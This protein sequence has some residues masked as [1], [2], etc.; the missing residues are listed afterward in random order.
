MAKHKTTPPDSE[1]R[2]R[3]LSEL[4]KSMLVEASAGTGKTT[5][6]VGRM[7]G[8]LRTGSCVADTLA[9]VTF[10][11]KS[12]AELRA[13]FQIG[14]EQ[15]ASS[16]ENNDERR[17]L[18]TALDGLDRSFIGTIH[19]FC[20]RLIRERPV[21]S[22]VDPGFVELDDDADAQ[23]RMQAWLEYVEEL[24]ATDDPILPEFE[25]LGLKVSAST[26]TSNDL[27]TELDELGLEPTDLGA[28]FL[29]LAEYPDV[30][31]W[32]A[33]QVALPDLTDCIDDLRVYVKHMLATEL[34]EKFGNDQ[35]MVKYRLIPRVLEQVQGDLIKPAELMPI[36]EQFREFT[37]KRIVQKNWLE[38]KGQALAE[39]DRWND[40]ALTHAEPLVQ[41]WR[42]HRYEPV[43]RAI[44]GAQ[45]VYDRL[46]REQ[47]TLNFQD[48]LLVSATLLR[49]QPLMRAYFRQRFSHLLIDEFQDTDPIQAEVMMLLTSD[50]DSETDWRLCRPSPGSL[51]VVGDPKQ[52]IYRFRRADIMTYEKVKTCIEASGGEVVSLTSN[53][54]SNEPI[55]NWINQCFEQVFPAATTKYSPANSPLQPSGVV[56][57]RAASNDEN[58]AGREGIVVL[59]H[60]NVG[61]QA[62]ARVAANEAEWIARSIRAAIDERQPVA[63]TKEELQRGLPEHVVPGDFMIV[64]RNRYKTTEYARA[65]QRYGLPNA[66]T[67][68]SI[69]NEVPEL[70]W[71]HLCLSSVDRADD[72]V[73]LVAVLRSELFGV[74][75]TT[76]YNFRRAGG[77]FNFRAPI[78]ETLKAAERD[79][80]NSAFTSLKQYANW[81]R[82]MPAEAAIEKIA[83]N[84]GLIASA[85][86][87]DDGGFHAG[88]LLKAIQLL[89]REPGIAV[90]DY[91]EALGRLVSS[92]ES[93]DG[94]SAS[95]PSETPVRVMNLH[96]CKGLEA[97][98]VFLAN[99]TG[100]ID[101]PV[102]IHIDRTELKPR[103]FFA[104]YGRRRNK[105]SFARAVLAQPPQWSDFAVEEQRFLDAEENRLLYVAATR[106]GRGLTIS[107]LANAS[108]NKK[109]P[110]RLFEADMESATQFVEPKSIASGRPTAGI[111]NN[112][113]SIEWDAVE[114]AIESRWMAVMQP[115]YAVQSIKAAAL[116]PGAKPRGELSHGAEWGNVLHSLLESLIQNPIGG[117]EGEDDA[118]D[119]SILRLAM[120]LLQQ[121]GLPSS[122]AN[123]VLN[124]ANR[125]ITSSVWRQATNS[126][127]CLSEVPIAWLDESESELK[128]IHRGVIDLAFWEPDGWWIVDYKTERVP[129]SELPALVDYYRP[130]IQAYS[131]AWRHVTDGAVVASQGILFT[132]T[133]DY[134]SI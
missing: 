111:E 113:D 132:A 72:P 100:E 117:S 109:N 124:T 106:A 33:E 14:L 20:S 86:A 58:S 3:I 127:Q 7:I 98:F 89:Q 59:R 47:G 77:I 84:L 38:G 10:T 21:E 11:R 35:L 116:S 103:G 55:I 80:L 41:A 134:F 53:F 37:R 49:E 63:R 56:A 78:P 82:K 122:L 8:L 125:V 93:H 19:A 24:L 102:G 104:I 57:T 95:P 60:P 45:H 96:Q 83:A 43:M 70:R 6:L 52:S 67:G 27:L 119:D 30:E 115:S 133:G 126:S 25:R 114:K 120:S 71:L 108:G 32:P 65:L 129:A 107:Q 69:L 79:Q 75:D 85:S 101:H 97:N 110:W 87:D 61:K 16:A 51:F 42:E 15:A 39:L 123:D 99:P 22:G 23:L 131:D 54:R 9:A 36:L 50:D 105:R 66:V 31:D 34:P 13:R 121:E 2:E 1:S 92:E 62:D 40:F 94:V 18:V 28:A 12:A 90:A 46:R 68:G 88:S 48:L 74:D 5:C 26:S 76:L 64:L 17:R 118:A 73:A 81:L 130:Q 44:R 128:T 112:T 4:D 91:V 29:R